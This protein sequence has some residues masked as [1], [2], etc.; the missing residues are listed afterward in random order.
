MLQ[1]SIIS[2]DADKGTEPRCMQTHASYITHMKILSIIFMHKT[3][4][5]HIASLNTQSIMCPRRVCCT[6]SAQSGFN[7]PL[8]SLQSPVDIAE[9]ACFAELSVSYR[10]PAH[11]DARWALAAAVL[12]VFEL[13]DLADWR[14]PAV[15][16]SL[17]EQLLGP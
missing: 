15:P 9:R 7:Q 11:F 2:A 5:E 14:D 16:D 13:V 4:C 1:A 8:Q 12:A 6:A 17:Q 3:A 10:R